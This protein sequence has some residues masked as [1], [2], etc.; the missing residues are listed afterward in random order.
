M[1]EV[2]GSSPVSIGCP[3]STNILNTCKRRLSQTPSCC[4]GAFLRLHLAMF[5]AFESIQFQHQVQTESAQILELCV[6]HSGRLPKQDLMNIGKLMLTPPFSRACSR[7]LILKTPFE[8]SK[9]KLSSTI[10][11]SSKTRL[12]YIRM[13]TGSIPC[14]AHR[15]K[16]VYPEASI[17]FRCNRDAFAQNR[18][19]IVLKLS[20]IVL[21]SS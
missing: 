15:R 3:F 21:K 8:L 16:K 1:R 12:I 10:S 13:A 2:P 11:I 19:Q 7:S 14:Y 20:Q 5:S 6:T 9:L 4:T 17:E 18:P